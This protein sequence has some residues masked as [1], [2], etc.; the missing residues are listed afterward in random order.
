MPERFWD[1][2]FPTASSC[3]PL[4]CTVLELPIEDDIQEDADENF[5]AA[6]NGKTQVIFYH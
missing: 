6:N 4:H 3:L 5:I 2:T 1:W